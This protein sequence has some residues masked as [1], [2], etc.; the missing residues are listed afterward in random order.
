VEEETFD[1]DL[2]QEHLKYLK[3]IKLKKGLKINSVE[4][5]KDDD[6]NHHIDFVTA[7][8]NLRARNY[9]IEEGSRH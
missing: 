3:S 6:T 4:F 2:I 7:C 9:K 5:E 8:A 1:E